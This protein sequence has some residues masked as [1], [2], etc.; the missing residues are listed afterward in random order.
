MTDV[1]TVPPDG[2]ELEV[3]VFGPGKGECIVV[4]VPNGPWF[5]VDSLSLRSAPVAVA[6]LAE[7]LKVDELWGLFLTHWHTDHTEGAA[8]TIEAFAPRMKIVGLPHGWGTRELAALAAYYVGTNLDRM[9]T[10]PVRELVKVL[11]VLRSPDCDAIQRVALAVRTELAPSGASWRLTALSPSFDDQTLLA[12]TLLKYLPGYSGPA[13][14]SFDPNTG[15]AVLRLETPPFVVT[16][17]SDLDAGQSKLHGWQAIVSHHADDLPS[18]VV[19]VG[20]HGSETAFHAEAWSAFGKKALPDAVI[21]PFPATGGHLP[22]KEMI[23]KLKERSRRLYLT[24]NARQSGKSQKGPFSSY[25]ALL[26]QVI[27]ERAFAPTLDIEGTA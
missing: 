6:Y 17:C 14:A 9:A 10:R 5:T 3:S 12:A 2:D 22:R 23:S 27:L 26:R 25:L 7:T 15:C 16:L 4:H 18:N 20:H 24:S 13:P 8:A 19:K 21:T 1:R 11:T